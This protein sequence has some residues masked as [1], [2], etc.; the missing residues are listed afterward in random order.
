M[1]R[2]LTLIILS[3]PGFLFSQWVQIPSPTADDL[4]NLYFINDSVGYAGY[5]DSEIVTYD[6][7]RSWSMNPGFVNLRKA[8]FVDSLNGFGITQNNFYQ[9]F[10]G[11]ANWISIRD[12]VEITRFNILECVNGKVFVVGNKSIQGAGYWY[13]SDD[14]G[15]SWEMR[16]QQDS[17]I[18]FRGRFVDDQNI[19]GAAVSHYFSDPALTMY[20]YMK[21]TDGG[22]TWQTIDFP[23]FFSTYDQAYDIFCPVV[24]TCFTSSTSYGF[25]L[26]TFR[27]TINQLNFSTGNSDTL[28][29]QPLK[30]LGFLEGYDQSLFIGGGGFLTVSPDRGTNWYDQDISFLSGFQTELWTCHAFSDS[31]AVVTGVDG[32][33]IRTDNFELGLTEH[34]SASPSFSVFPNPS[35]GHQDISVTALTPGTMCNIELFDLRGNKVKQVFSGLSQDKELRIQVNLSDLAAGSYFYRVQTEAGVSQKKI[36]V[37]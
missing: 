24:D 26:H 15:A 13:A 31:S 28:L 8:C 3:L 32:C 9:T 6:G 17:T 21:S 36:V 37:H 10:D 35:T 25:G 29:H 5:G 1:N 23:P 33:I 22:Y 20:H 4:N 7:G 2:I 27:F 12:S 14:V 16:Y 18:F 30:A 19:F 11:G 34:P